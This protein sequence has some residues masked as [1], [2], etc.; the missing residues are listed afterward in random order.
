MAKYKK[1]K[2]K[3]NDKA[4]IAVAALAAVIV[5]AVIAVVLVRT[6][7]SAVQTAAT[8]DGGSDSPGGAKT[9]GS[10]NTSGE[11]MDDSAVREL[12]EGE[13]P[14][15]IEIQVKT[16]AGYVEPGKDTLDIQKIQG[17]TTQAG[18]EESNPESAESSGQA[19]TVL[20]DPNLSVNAVGSYTGN[21]LE[22]GSD[23]PVADVASIL[24]TN[25]SAQM[26]QVGQ[27]TFQVNDTET[28]TFKVTNLPA[29]TSALV[30]EQN[31]REYKEDDDYSYG[32]TA[33]AY[34]DS[35]SLESD[36]FDIEMENGKVRVIN[37]TDQAY[38]RVYVYYKYVQ[39]G[40]AYKGGITYRTPVENVPANGS[41]E[42]VAGHMNPDGTLVV[43]VQI[44]E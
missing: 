41:A 16:S 17:F 36:K 3:R 11:I 1:K 8:Q 42:A 15:D 37:K 22:D 30:M 21:F 23:E 2:R 39:M 44:A 29:G 9:G 6:G 38:S 35:P 19:G 24:I 28:A 14:E 25:N 5:I 4:I 40:G 34:I 26:L 32:N 43:D 13:N 18:G 7:K 33:T 31:R 20:S 27:V 10:V 12:A